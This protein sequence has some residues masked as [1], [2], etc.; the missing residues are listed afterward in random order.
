MKDIGFTKI[1]DVG[2]PSKAP[3]ERTK[4]TFEQIEANRL[5]DEK[6]QR[7]RRLQ[8]IQAKIY[9]RREH[10]KRD[11]AKVGYY[12]DSFEC[13]FAVV[14]EDDGAYSYHFRVVEDDDHSIKRAQVAD[15]TGLAGKCYTSRSNAYA[16]LNQ[17]G[18][19]LTDPDC[20]FAVVQRMP[21]RVEIVLKRVIEAD[22]IAALVETWHEHYPNVAV[23]LLTL[24]ATDAYK[25]FNEPK[26]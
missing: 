15:K 23:D 3:T 18:H 14:R 19:Y 9:T 10:A 12:L 25:F 4:L 20:P 11:L 6:E 16:A 26:S 21:G 2:E 1:E 13:P 8:E 17:R 22:A 5:R 7:K 24:L